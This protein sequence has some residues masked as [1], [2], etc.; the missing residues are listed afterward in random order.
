M[1]KLEAAREGLSRFNFGRCT[2]GSATHRFK[3]QWG[4]VDEPLF[5]YQ[6]RTT[7]IAGT[8]SADSAKFRLATK[9]WKRLPLPLANV[10]GPQLVRYIP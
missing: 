9:L 1:R 5:W 7:R 10:L 8:P 2:P 6:G 4:A 3:S